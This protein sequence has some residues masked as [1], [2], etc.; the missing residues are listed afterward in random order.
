MVAFGLTTTIERWTTITAQQLTAACK[1]INCLAVALETQ[2][3]EI[4]C[5][6]AHAGN[7]NMPH[8]YKLNCRHVDTP[9]PSQQGGSVLPKWIK[10]LGSREV[11]AQAEED[12]DKAE[13]MV[14]LNLPTDYSHR[15]LNTMPY[16]CEELLQSTG[17]PFFALAMVVRSLDLTASAEIKWYQCHHQQQSQL[18]AD[19]HAIITEIKHEDEE[20]TTICHCLE[21]W[22]LHE[23]VAHLQH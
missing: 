22:H 18:K 14:P 5:L 4:R 6:R 9:I 1:C 12:V 16:W 2:D 21:E 13:Y 15:E 3:S 19:R 17:T 8:D 23:W 7:V 10:V 20:L 11:I